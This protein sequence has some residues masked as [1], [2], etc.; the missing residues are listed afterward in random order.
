[1]DSTSISILIIVVLIFLIFTYYFYD[2]WN[3]HTL[4][5]IIPTETEPF[6]ESPISAQLD[7]PPMM[8]KFIPSSKFI[9]SKQ[10]Y[11]FYNSNEYGLGYH[12]DQ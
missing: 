8:P 2:L 3:K 4:N 12:L 1:M 6:L 9:G 11:V 7:T 5:K 10:G